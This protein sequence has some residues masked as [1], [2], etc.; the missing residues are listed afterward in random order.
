[1]ALAV[2]LALQTLRFESPRLQRFQNEVASKLS[3]IPAAKVNTE[4]IMLLR[5]LNAL[6]PPRDSTSDFLPQ[7]RVVFLMKALNSWLTSDD[8]S[9]DFSEELES[10][11]AELYENLGPIVQDVPGAHWETIFDLISNNLEVRSL[12]CS[13]FSTNRLTKRG[14]NP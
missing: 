7:Q 9:G 6:A 3:G 13:F 12:L 1:V 4:G 2:I 5:L 10:R 14:L 8:Y 11:M